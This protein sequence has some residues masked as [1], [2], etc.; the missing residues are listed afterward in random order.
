MH[1]NYF[2]RFKMI[3]SPFILR[4][5]HTYVS[6]YDNCSKLQNDLSCVYQWSLKQQFTLNH[7]KYKAINN[8]NKHSSI[9][10]LLYGTVLAKTCHVH[11]KT[12][13]NFIA[14][15]YRHTQYLSI[16]SVSS[17]NV[18]WLTF[19]KGILPTTQSHGWNNSTHGGCQLGNGDL[20]LLPLTMWPTGVSLATAW[21]SWL[22]MKCLIEKYHEI[23]PSEK[24]EVSYNKNQ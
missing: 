15:L 8:S 2:F 24:D 9:N 23:Q 1:T 20:D 14:I 4:Y 22:L 16:P 13:F 21:V 7:K 17:I 12:E 3:L 5:I 11:T 19:L 6:C 18:N 10:F